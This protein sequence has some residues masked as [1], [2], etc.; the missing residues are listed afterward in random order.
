MK[1]TK[2]THNLNCIVFFFIPATNDLKRNQ[3]TTLWRPQKAENTKLLELKHKTL[4][5]N[6][7][8]SL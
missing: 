4:E 1:N 2:S 7:G 8:G 5:A 3:E 6:L